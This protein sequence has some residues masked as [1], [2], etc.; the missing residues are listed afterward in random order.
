MSFTVAVTS[1][2]VGPSLGGLSGGVTIVQT[3]WMSPGEPVEAG[4]QE[5]SRAGVSTPLKLKVKT[6]SGVAKISTGNPNG[7]AKKVGPSWAA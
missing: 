4:W 2:V 5:A 3:S 6:V 1:I 7:L